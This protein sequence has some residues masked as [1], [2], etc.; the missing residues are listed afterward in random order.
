MSCGLGLVLLVI[1]ISLPDA[2]NE[3][4]KQCSHS[5]GGKRNTRDNYYD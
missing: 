3:F 5:F 1:I 4:K 2:Y